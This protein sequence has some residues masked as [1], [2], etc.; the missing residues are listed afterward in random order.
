M[1]GVAA[2]VGDKLGTV[3]LLG[4]VIAVAR[5]ARAGKAHLAHDPWL[6]HPLKLEV[7]LDFLGSAQAVV[8]DLRAW[9]VRNVRHWLEL[10]LRH[11]A[12]HD[13][14]LVVIGVRVAR[15]AAVD[16][17]Q[18]QCA[19]LRVASEAVG[20]D[21]CGQLELLKR[22]KDG[23]LGE[24][25]A[26]DQLVAAQQRARE[27]GWHRLARRDARQPLAAFSEPPAAQDGPIKGGR[28]LHPAQRAATLGGRGGGAVDDG[29]DPRAVE[30]FLFAKEAHSRALGEREPHVENVHVPGAREGVG[31]GG[32]RER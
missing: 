13:L 3:E 10:A 15:T 28:A 9:V 16:V 17:R 23:A 18:T 19:R 31:R 20:H 22:L 14:A 25:A 30:A 21:R 12:E 2:R 11:A 4:I 1:V 24:P 26:V 7:A 5:Q 29:G 32:N 8:F 27:L 6:R